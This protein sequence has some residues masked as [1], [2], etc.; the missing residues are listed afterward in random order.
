MRGFESIQVA[1]H[2]RFISSRGIKPSSSPCFF[3]ADL[4]SDLLGLKAVDIRRFPDNSG[5]LINHIWTKSLRSGILMFLPLEGV[6]MQLY[7]LLN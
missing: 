6:K 1:S 2:L 3:A 7:A 4:A 5:V